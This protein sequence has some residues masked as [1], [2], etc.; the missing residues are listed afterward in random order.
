MEKWVV[1]AKR[2][3]FK[4]IA[5][6]FQIDQVTARIIRNRDVTGEEQIRRYLHPT[7]GDLYPAALLTGASDAG[8][9]LKRKILEKKKIRIIG[10]YDIDGVMA[11]Y[12]LFRGLKRCGADADYEIPDRMKDGFGLNRSLIELAFTEGADTVITCDNGIAAIEEIAYAKQLGLTVIVTD[13]HEPVYEET[14]GEKQYRYP[15]AD[16][17]VD[18]AVPE[19][20][21]P[22]R[23]ICGAV[24]AWKVIHELF[25]AFQI[26]EG[27]WLRFLPFAAFATV[28]D[29]MDL[30][31]ENR[32][33]VRLGL[34][35]L[36]LTDNIGM[37]ALIRACSLEGRRLTAY[38]I[39]FVLGP[40][41]NAGG[42][43]DTAKRSLRLLLCEEE[44]QAQ[45]LAVRLRE[46]ND[47]RKQMTDFCISEACERIEQGEFA[48]DDVYVIYLKQCHESIA[49][50]IAGKVRERYYHPVIILTDSQTP[51]LLKGSG[52]STE[53]WN[54]YE[55]LVRCNDLM[56]KYGGHPMAAGIT[57]RKEKLDAFRKAL[58]ENSG[59]KEE[60]FVRKIVI[61]VPMP[62]SYLRED[63][64]E[65][66]ELLEPF[67]KGNEKP[68]FAEK[69]LRFR[70]AS[71]I[72][73]NQ[74]TVK[75]QAVLENGGVV[76]A[77]YFGDA[78][79]M[80]SYIREKYG[81]QETTALLQGRENY[82]SLSVTYY[83][84]INEYRGMRTIQIV[85][86][87]YR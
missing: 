26:S 31:D 9:L 54:M 61:D 67:G 68:V 46:L 33:I 39:G 49:G 44:D 40:C 2:A 32:A 35:P 48:G 87:G 58:N 47:L 86:S 23:K 25:A 12:I 70:R 14:G 21:Y 66:L 34:P 72:G 41:I 42:R 6:T 27:E 76:D 5:D 18:P 65:E 30:Q 77:L 10:D 51:G 11:T 28:G 36:E 69:N 45:V 4:A 13:H 79:G 24:V 71:V 78:E 7:V 37:R 19:N 43:L 29:V 83:P 59:L 63:L 85:I 8:L 38:H 22:F 16:V 52:R 15:P 53:T 3:D 81:E 20:T 82:V 60:D 74:N 75:L 55:G 57:L 80:L 62:L 73:A 84:S 17:V 1:S 56:E 64:I 50:I